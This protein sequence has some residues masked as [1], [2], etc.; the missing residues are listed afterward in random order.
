MISAYPTSHA[1]YRTIRTSGN[2]C[3]ACY[4]APC[5]LQ[6]FVYA[7]QFFEVYTLVFLSR[8]NKFICVTIAKMSPCWISK[9]NCKVRL[10]TQ[11]M[12]WY[13]IKVII[14]DWKSRTVSDKKLYFKTSGINSIFFG[15]IW[16]S[17]ICCQNYQVTLIWKQIVEMF[18][19]KKV[20]GQLVENF[21][22]SEKNIYIAWSHS[23]MLNVRN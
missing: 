18:S 10:R 17:H 2:A 8:R 22:F 16:N 1:M 23:F 11:D 7:M 21:P 9:Q 5:V 19:I 3:N 13:L 15:K 20:M 4:R 12:R 14:R 6:R